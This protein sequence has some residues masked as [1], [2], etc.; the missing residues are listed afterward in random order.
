[1]STDY[2]FW[3]L[4]LAASQV[5]FGIVAGPDPL[6]ALGVQLSKTAVTSDSNRNTEENEKYL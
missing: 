6:L 3:T 5:L 2:Q 4:I 1:M